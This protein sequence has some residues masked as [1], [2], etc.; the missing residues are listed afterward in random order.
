MISI[1]KIFES[2]KF[3]KIEELFVVIRVH[4]MIVKSRMREIL[5]LLV[6]EVEAMIPVKVGKLDLYS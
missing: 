2:S 3:Y 4:Q 1:K 6:Q 5:F